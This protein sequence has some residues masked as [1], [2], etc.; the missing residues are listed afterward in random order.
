MSNGAHHV[1]DIFQNGFDLYMKEKTFVLSTNRVE[2][3]DFRYPKW[4]YSNSALKIQMQKRRL[5]PNTAPRNHIS[6]FTTCTNVQLD[7][8]F[9]QQQQQQTLPHNTFTHD[10]THYLVY[11]VCGAELK[12]FC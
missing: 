7:I 8:I 12:L 3:G 9:E 10:T 11:C 2:S 4:F 1:L 6:T 5:L